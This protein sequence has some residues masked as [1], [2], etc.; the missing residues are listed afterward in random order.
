LP[1]V[2]VIAG[3]GDLFTVAEEDLMAAILAVA[4]VDDLPAGTI[5]VAHPVPIAMRDLMVAFSAQEGRHSP[6]I[7]VPWQLVLGVLRTTEYLGVR[8]PFRADSL[9]GLVRTAP[10]I[11]NGEAVARM[12]VTV[13]PFS[14]RTT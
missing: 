2:P 5:S 11:V 9:L 1:I 14:T 7:P 3:A 6:F 4:T 10:E 13:H 12:G 8:L